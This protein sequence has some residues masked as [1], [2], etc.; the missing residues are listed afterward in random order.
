MRQ[1]VPAEV[2]EAM[3]VDTNGYPLPNDLYLLDQT[4]YCR[5]LPADRS[6]RYPTYATC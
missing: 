2:A 4:G 6:S 1:V 3:K 5:R